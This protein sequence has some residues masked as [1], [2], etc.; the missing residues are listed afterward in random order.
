MSLIQIKGASKT[1]V[2]LVLIMAIITYVLLVG[3]ICIDNNELYLTI[4]Q[5]E[6]NKKAYHGLIAQGEVVLHYIHS[7]DGT[8]VTVIFEVSVEG[9]NLREERYYWHGAGL[10]TGSGRNITFENDEV[11]VSGYRQVYNELPIR[12][13]Q[14]VPQYLEVSG[15]KIILPDLVTGGDLLIVRIEKASSLIR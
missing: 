8:P 14:T 1:E 15:E 11:V 10:E 13:A 4:Y 2:V 7:S 9:L 6:S 3:R 5:A 12:I